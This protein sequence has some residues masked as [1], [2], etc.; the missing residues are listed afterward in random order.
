MFVWQFIVEI[1]SHW[2]E[3]M[4]LMIRN[5]KKRVRKQKIKKLKIKMTMNAA[6]Q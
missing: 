5:F 4:R 2:F 6:T 3:S 1:V